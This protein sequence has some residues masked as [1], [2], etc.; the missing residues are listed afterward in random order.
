MARLPGSTPIP[1]Q[2]NSTTLFDRQDC[3]QAKGK[4]SDYLEEDFIRDIGRTPSEKSATI[5]P[6]KFHPEA[7]LNHTTLYSVPIDVVIVSG[8]K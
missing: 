1:K 7:G 2:P 8:V 4:V 3:T 6:E 5:I